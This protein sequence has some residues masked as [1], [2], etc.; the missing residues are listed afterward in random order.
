[1]G[2]FE[3]KRQL[4]GLLV[5]TP[6]ILPQALFLQYCV[7][8]H[9][10]LV[11]QNCGMFGLSRVFLETKLSA[12]VLVALVAGFGVVVLSTAGSKPQADMSATNKSSAVQGVHRESCLIML[13]FLFVRRL[14]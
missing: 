9:F 5:Q 2:D 6:A 4:V 10:A 7:L 14:R 12:L 1:M 3:V 8:L 11:V 13:Q